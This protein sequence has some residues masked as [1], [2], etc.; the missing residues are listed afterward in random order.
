M[1][2]GGI[3]GLD[4]SNEF[5]FQHEKAAIFFWLTYLKAFI[6]RYSSEYETSD[7]DQILIFPG[8]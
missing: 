2:Y 5:L 1:W 4:E 7:S 3:L 6:V 8:S